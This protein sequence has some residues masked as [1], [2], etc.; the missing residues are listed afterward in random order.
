MATLHLH[1][2]HH[3]HQYRYLHPG[4]KKMTSTEQLDYTTQFIKTTP[5]TLITQ[6]DAFVSIQYS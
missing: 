6:D 2:H 4:K 5:I 3:R 1:R